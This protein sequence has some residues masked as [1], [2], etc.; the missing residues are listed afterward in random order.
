MWHMGT[1]MSDRLTF[2]QTNMISDNSLKASD[3][4]LKTHENDDAQ[5]KLAWGAENES[6][7]E[8]PQT[9][10]EHTLP[11]LQNCPALWQ[12]WVLWGQDVSRQLVRHWHTVGA[13]L[14][15]WTTQ[16][17]NLQF[18]EEETEVH[19][20]KAICPRSHTW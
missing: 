1:R 14:T 7:K 2:P 18:P 3:K 12:Q 15:L 8:K 19:K 5:A 10:N 11:E 9:E 20:G 13:L 17:I 16:G 4:R 6:V